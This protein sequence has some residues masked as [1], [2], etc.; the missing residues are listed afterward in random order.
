MLSFVGIAGKQRKYNDRGIFPPPLVPRSLLD[1]I[2][3]PETSGKVG[4]I[5]GGAKL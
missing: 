4:D 1:N 2:V 3:V 5:V